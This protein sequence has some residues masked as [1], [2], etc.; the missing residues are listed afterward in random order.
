MSG[1]NPYLST[2]E[3]TAPSQMLE[4]IIGV[5]TSGFINHR[6]KTFVL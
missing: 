3:R 6:I 2:L 4:I 1:A 5:S